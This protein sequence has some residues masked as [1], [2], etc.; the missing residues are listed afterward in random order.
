MVAV[1]FKQKTAYEISWCDWSSDVCSSDLLRRVSPEKLAENLNLRKGLVGIFTLDQ[2]SIITR[3][4]PCDIKELHE[5]HQRI[6]VAEAYR[7]DFFSDES[8]QKELPKIKI[9]AGDS[10]GPI[11]HI[12]LQ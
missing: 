5:M 10:S 1:S 2:Y 9:F 12:R 6:L 3:R 8:P 11:N 7:P 4:V